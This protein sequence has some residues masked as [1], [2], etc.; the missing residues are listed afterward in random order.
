MCLIIFGTASVSVAK[1][2]SG[3]FFEKASNLGLSFQKWT[4][5]SADWILSSLGV[6]PMSPMEGIVYYNPDDAVKE[7]TKD[8]KNGQALST[9]TEANVAPVANIG[10]HIDNVSCSGGEVWVH[11]IDNYAPKSSSGVKLYNYLGKIEIFGK[12][13]MGSV[14]TPVYKSNSISFTNGGATIRVFSEESLPKEQVEFILQVNGE[15]VSMK[16]FDP[17]PI[18][19]S[20]CILDLFSSELII[21]ESKIMEIYDNSG[22][23]QR[24][25]LDEERL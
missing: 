25:K 21:V 23:F 11:V 10:I 22:F 5:Q 17:S 3:S 14:I 18:F 4:V 1:A 16:L 9:S 2:D 20:P 13:S 6:P 19:L 24:G 7:N 15:R 8:S 12:N